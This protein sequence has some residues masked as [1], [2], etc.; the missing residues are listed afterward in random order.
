[1]E[2]VEGGRGG[3]AKCP[4]VSGGK[5]SRVITWGD[6]YTGYEIPGGGKRTYRKISGDKCLRVK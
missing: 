1:M 6:K 4:E 3:G 5:C 2:T